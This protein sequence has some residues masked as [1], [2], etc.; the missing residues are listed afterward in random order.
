MNLSIHS[1]LHTSGSIS[2]LDNVNASL[3]C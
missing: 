3:S 1:R 2:T